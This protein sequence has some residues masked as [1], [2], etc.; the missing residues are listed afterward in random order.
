[1]K[2]NLNEQQKRSEIREESQQ[3]IKDIVNYIK[4]PKKKKET[5]KDFELLKRYNS[6]SLDSRRKVLIS[7]KDWMDTFIETQ[8]NKEKQ[9]H[10]KNEGH[11]YDE[12]QYKL[13]TKNVPVYDA[14]VQGYID[15]ECSEWYRICQRCGNIEK[16]EYE[17]KAVKE[18]RKKKKK[19][20]EIKTL[21]KRLK[22]LKG[23]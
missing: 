13:Y 7:L 20:E 15:V 1:M 10:C 23:E 18:A 22:N 8:E 9:E 12:W 17:P 19:Q 21:E 5:E 2:N 11:V 14:G 3:F 16:S 4:T 6:L